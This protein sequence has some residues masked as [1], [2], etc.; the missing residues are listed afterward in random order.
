MWLYNGTL[1][2]RHEE[3][4]LTLEGTF[5]SLYI[6]PILDVLTKQNPDSSFLTTAKTHNG[7]F[8]TSS[9]QTLY[10]FVDVKTGMLVTYL[11]F[12]PFDF[13]T[14]INIKN[15]LRVM[16]NERSCLYTRDIARPHT[17]T[18]LDGATAW[19]IV[20]KALEPL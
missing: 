13:I 9:G 19:P 18:K 16:G 7:V 2:V 12:T 5:E 17:N 3:S 1:Y 4:A 14:F 20:V 15:P 11:N 8:D 10:L 6:N